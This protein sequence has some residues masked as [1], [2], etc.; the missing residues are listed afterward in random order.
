MTPEEIPAL[1]ESLRGEM[2]RAAEALDFERAAELRDRIRSLTQTEL[3]LKDPKPPRRAPAA[4]SR[5][6]S[7]RGARRPG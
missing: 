2:L 4:A 5:Q 3:L 7:R 1:V 6:R